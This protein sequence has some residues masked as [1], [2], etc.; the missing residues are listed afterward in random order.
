MNPRPLT[1]ARQELVVAHVHLARLVALEWLGRRTARSAHLVRDDVFRREALVVAQTS[2]VFAAAQWDGVRPFNPY[3]TTVVWLGLSRWLRRSFVVPIDLRAHRKGARSYFT[4]MDAQLPDT[5]TPTPFESAERRMAR[6]VVHK[7]HAA[8][9]AA[10][11]EEDARP[12]QGRRSRFSPEERVR[13]WWRVD[14]LGETLESVGRETGV[15]REAVRQSVER[16]RA[17]FEAWA[18]QVRAEAA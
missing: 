18:A 14:F 12:R 4:E 7:A 8:I 6:R 2:L 1:V 9:A 5:L 10:V 16:I 11:A 17:H 13:Q 3:A 15:T